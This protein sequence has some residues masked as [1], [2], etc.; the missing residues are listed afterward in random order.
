MWGQAFSVLGTVMNDRS[1]YVSREFLSDHFNVG[2]VWDYK[3]KT[4]AAD[5][6]NAVE[7]K[8]SSQTPVA[9][10]LSMTEGQR[11]IDQLWDCGI[12]PS[13]GSGSA[14]QL[15]ATQKHLED[16]RTLVFKP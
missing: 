5:L 6:P 1:I 3:G 15:A 12:R 4:F 10:R 16:M 7:I 13:E 14:G 9:L 11:L 8:E 2:I